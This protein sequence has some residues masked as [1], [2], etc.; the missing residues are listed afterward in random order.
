M[1]VSFL[2]LFELL[3]AKLKH[4]HDEGEDDKKEGGR[5]E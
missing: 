5:N 4:E 3:Q 2:F 1:Q